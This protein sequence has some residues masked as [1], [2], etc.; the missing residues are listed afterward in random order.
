M[1]N[2]YEYEIKFHVNSCKSFFANI[3]KI[4]INRPLFIK[5]C[6]ESYPP[7]IFKNHQ[8]RKRD[9][10]STTSLFFFLYKI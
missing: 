8:Y 10:F 1:N 3:S 6:L 4:K 2:R 9:S 7:K 5:N